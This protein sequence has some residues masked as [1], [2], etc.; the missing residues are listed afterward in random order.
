MRRPLLTLTCAALLAVPLQADTL[1]VDGSGNPGSFF[2]LAD[3]VAAAA[4]GD[5]ILVSQLAMDL[6][7]IVDGKSLTIVAD[8]GAAPL[9]TGPVFVRDLLPGQ[10]VL[11]DGLR[12]EPNT[13]GPGLTVFDCAG[14]VLVQDCTIA[15]TFL[16]VA[17]N[18]AA[19][20]ADAAA[21][22]FSRC[23]LTGSR[24]LGVTAGAGLRVEAGSV[25]GAYDC[26]IAGGAGQ[27]TG[28]TA[29]TGGTGAEVVGGSL[30]VSGGSL[31][32]GPGG[33]GDGIF[34]DTDGSDGGVGLV[35]L[36][37]SAE[38]RL[39]AVLAQGG[40]G[41]DAPAPFLPGDPGTDV[42]A[43]P[44]VVE[45]VETTPRSLVV[46]S[47]L[48]D[49]ETLVAELSGEPFDLVFTV[50]SAEQAPQVLPSPPVSVKVGGPLVPSLSSGFLLP[51]FSLDGNGQAT[52]SAPVVGAALTGTAY[53]QP[54][55]VGALHVNANPAAITVLAT[56]L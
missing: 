21:V 4:D 48:R 8:S 30:F 32:G 34:G 12:V 11:L 55:H 29:F 42:L 3:A 54:I 28:L 17:P 49:G 39:V 6:P 47:P 14:S 53:V 10:Q 2:Q 33:D 27:V 20:V 52:L 13:V 16:P 51:V 15:G 36:N 45:E 18:P 24:S 19:R 26:Q 23:T 43:L 50:V 5:T 46:A 37:P 38:V 40:P 22:V 31:T 56:G 7:V 25:V 35:A 41:G 44:D 1:L 9:L